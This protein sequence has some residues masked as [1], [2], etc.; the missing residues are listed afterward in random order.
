MSSKQRCAVGWRWLALAA[1]AWLVACSAAAPVREA[2]TPLAQS[3]STHSTEDDL[4]TAGLGWAGLASPVPPANDGTAAALRRRAVWTNWR[5]IALISEAGLGAGRLE[6]P[7]VPGRELHAVL[8]LPQSGARHRVMLQIPD[9]FD[10]ARPCLVV[11]ASSG[12]RGIYGAIALAGGWGLPRGC[13]VA[14]TDKGAGSDWIAAGT[15]RGPGLDGRLPAPS[16]Q[17]VRYEL[18]APAASVA[19]PHAH[20]A[21]HPEADWGRH[22]Q[23]TAQWARAQL[24]SLEPAARKASASDWRIIAT[25]VSNG[26][27]AVLQAAALDGWEVDA[28]VAISPNVPPHRGGRALYDYATEAALFMPCA[29][30]SAS[31]ASAL[32]PVEGGASLTRCASLLRVGLLPEGRLED[33]AEA[34]LAHLAAQGWSPAALEGAVAST[35]LDLWRAVGAGYASAYLRRGPDDMPCGFRYVAT[36]QA[37]PS[38]WWSDSSGIPPGAGVQLQGPEDSRADPQFASLQCLRAL[39]T[40]DSAEAASLRAAVEATRADA[41]RDDLP[42]WLLHGEDDGLVPIDFSSAAYRDAQG[43]SATLHWQPLPR[44]QH[45]DSLLG[46]PAAAQRYQALMPSAYAALDAAWDWLAANQG[47]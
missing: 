35:R 12:S 22:V 29:A 38:L 27:G 9:A 43:S 45:F 40:G 26:G 23:Q 10:P 37:D 20:S 33:A 14:Y 1:P 25:G 5:G 3:L 46:L 36:E 41:L 39:W 16:A 19:I 6:Q 24:E 44:A 42:L 8:A 11:S 18:D 21:A 4:L 28:V 30:A 34:A 31:L 47:R 15:T 17:A 13:A 7:A 32:L 2:P